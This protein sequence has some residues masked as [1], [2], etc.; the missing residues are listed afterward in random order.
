MYLLDTNVLSRL[1]RKQPDAGL[2]ERLREHE[3]EGLFTSCICVMELRHGAMRRTDEGRLWRRIDREILS[4]VEILGIGMDDAVLA[5]DVL[6]HLWS[7]GQPID[8]EDVLIGASALR[9]GFTVV[10]DNV[11]HFTR[12]PDLAVQD[13]TS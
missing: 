10:T 11:A 7:R 1:I 5:G 3:A 12:I 4:R 2:L 8:V 13:W 6:A 9:R